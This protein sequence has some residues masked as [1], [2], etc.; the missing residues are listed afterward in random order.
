MFLS[1]I[2]GMKSTIYPDPIPSNP[3]ASQVG[4][5]LRHFP[6]ALKIM[7]RRKS[8]RRAGS[9]GKASK[10]RVFVWFYCCEIMETN[11]SRRNSFQFMVSEVS[12][13]PGSREQSRWEPQKGVRV[14][15]STRGHLPRPTSS[16]QAF[17]SS[18]TFQQCVENIN[19]STC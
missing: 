14:K 7:G 5:F 11:H 15:S 1:P 6:L 13:H 8:Q 19:P 17:H 9:D 2:D 3:T 4:L 10:A 12:P 18:I 16:H